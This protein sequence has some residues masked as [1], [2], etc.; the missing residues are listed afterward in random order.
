MIIDDPEKKQ[1][2]TFK[3]QNQQFFVLFY[4]KNDWN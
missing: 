1:I 4:L 3:R 2:L